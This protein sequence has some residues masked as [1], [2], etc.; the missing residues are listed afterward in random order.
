MILNAKCLIRACEELGV[1]YKQLDKFGNFVA[2][3]KKPHYFVNFS[4]PLNDQGAVLICRDKG[5][6]HD[7]LKDVVNMPETLQFLDPKVGS[8][9]KQYAV[10][11]SE[12][13]IANEVLESL[14]LPVVVKP[15]RGALS[16][17]VELCRSRRDV[18]KAFKQIFS[19]K[20][21]Y[22]YVAL[23]QQYIDPEKEYR[24][25][26]AGGKVKI[27]YEKAKTEVAKGNNVMNPRFWEGSKSVDI[28]EG[29]EIFS[30]LQEFVQPAIDQIDLGWGA[31]DILLDKK[32]E[33]WFL[34]INDSP[35]FE[36][37][38]E[39]NGEDKLV[40]VYKE[41]VQSLTLLDS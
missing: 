40:E 30:R 34:E 36:F 21:P 4:T 13:E 3:G 27:V 28:D 24:V 2:V 10:H 29:E 32:G 20:L 39:H 38:V 22:S 23:A 17:N 33:L 18:I 26:T 35:K 11:S 15:G 5:F 9:F 25:I 6:C 19:R 16:N 1:S 12:K 31:M 8:E 37:Y 7:A 14:D 41:A